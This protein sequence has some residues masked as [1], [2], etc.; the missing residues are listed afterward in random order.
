MLRRT[1]RGSSPQDR[2]LGDPAVTPNPCLAPVERPPFHAVPV[3]SRDGAPLEGLFAAG[4]SAATLFRDMYPGGGA[5]LASAIV[6]AH[7]AGTRIAL[8]LHLVGDEHVPPAPI[9][10]LARRVMANPE[11]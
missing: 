9:T 7:R 5:T 3:R 2:H 6:R 10:P 1:C 8:D 4:N 11:P